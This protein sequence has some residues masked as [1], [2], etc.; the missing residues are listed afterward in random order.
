MSLLACVFRVAAPMTFFFFFPNAVI[1][2]LGQP[3]SPIT[4]CML[5]PNPPVIGYC[6]PFLSLKLPPVVVHS[7]FIAVAEPRG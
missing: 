3:R 4:R 5:P 2:K 1:R 6:S 7:V